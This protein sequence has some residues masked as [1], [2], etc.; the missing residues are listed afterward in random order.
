MS[1]GRDHLLAT[2][3]TLRPG[4]PNEHIMAGMD[5][6]WSPAVV[7]GRL[8]ASGVGRATGYPGVVLDESAEPVPVQLFASADLP[9]HWGRLDEFEGPGYRRVPVRVRVP[10]EERTLTAWIYELVPEAVPLE[11]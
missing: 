3:G 11:G 7:H 10:V 1:T 6:S 9:A 2:Y 4:E 8:Y 5:G